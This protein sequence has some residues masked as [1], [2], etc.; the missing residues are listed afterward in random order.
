MKLVID[1]SVWWRGTPS[2]LLRVHN[3]QR[4]QCCIGIY[5]TACGLSDESI[6]HTGT[7]DGIT[8]TGIPDWLMRGKSNS[9]DALELIHVN[10]MRGLNP[11]EEWHREA[12]VAD[13]FARHDVQTEFVDGPVAP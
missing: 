10:D 13:I 2:Q 6:A 7:P 9:D 12:K 4:Q 3:G 5:L 8:E 11:S 1:R